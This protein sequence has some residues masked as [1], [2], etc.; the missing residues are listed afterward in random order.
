MGTRR[1]WRRAALAALLLL[2]GG[3]GVAH[4]ADLH[5]VQQLE[6]RQ[7]NVQLLQEQREIYLQGNGAILRN[8]THF[9][10]IRA[11]M[12]RAWLLDA[13]R[14]PLSEIPVDQVRGELA[15]NRFNPG[16][17]PPI[18]PTKE[19][20]KLQGLTCHVYRAAASQLTVEACVTRQL[21]ALEQFRDLLGAKAEVPGVPLE[22]VIQIAAPDQS[23]TYSIRQTLLKVETTRLD[24]GLFAPP[25]TSAA[26]PPPAS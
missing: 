2:G 19:T 16:P 8:P 21:A 13:D 22:F 10:L 5:L 26:P 12:Q 6:I 18:Q 11:D 23:A 14:Q 1:Q 15:G 17:L 7:G 9:F 3:L 20:R 24:P 25:A 4:A